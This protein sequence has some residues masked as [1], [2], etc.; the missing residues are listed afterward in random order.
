MAMDSMS[1]ELF[2]AIKGEPFVDEV[3]YLP[4]GAAVTSE[5]LKE[6]WKILKRSH[7]IIS[8]PYV[9]KRGNPVAAGIYSRFAQYSGDTEM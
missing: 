7:L 9:T 2:D 8:D 1:S 5:E 4:P 3:P 6:L